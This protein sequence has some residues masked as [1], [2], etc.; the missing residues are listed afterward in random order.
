MPPPIADSFVASREGNRTSLFGS[1]K[2]QV[3]RVGVSRSFGTGF[4]RSWGNGTTHA[5]RERYEAG[6]LW[7]SDGQARTAWPFP[8]APPASRCDTLLNSEPQVVSISADS[9]FLLHMLGRSRVTL[10]PNPWPSQ[11]P[12]RTRDRRRRYGRGCRIL[13]CND[14]VDR[15]VLLLEIHGGGEAIA[16]FEHRSDGRRGIFR[17]P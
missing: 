8:E 7:G 12:T 1:G 2:R 17:L 6:S 5:V 13:V 11:P 10:D 16:A 14:P 4:D 3:P 15:G 9:L